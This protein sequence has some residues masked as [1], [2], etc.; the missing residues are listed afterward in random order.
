MSGLGPPI[1]HTLILASGSCRYLARHNCACPGA[2]VA[3]AILAPGGVRFD[4]R[5]GIV[6][7]GVCTHLV[8]TS[9]YIAELAAVAQ[10]LTSLGELVDDHEFRRHYNDALRAIEQVE[11]SWS[12]SYL[13]Y[14]ARCYY[15]SFTK[16]PS[17]DPFHASTGLR[18]PTRWRERDLDD[19][20]TEIQFP[21]SRFKFDNRKLEEAVARR[22]VARQR[23]TIISILSS[24]LSVA[25]D[26][27]YIAHLLKTV[28]DGTPPSAISIA[29]SFVPNTSYTTN[30]T[31]A[32]NEGGQ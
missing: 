22:V 13:G 24:Y 3:N 5:L 26:D 15:G 20:R 27:S 12:R 32:L 9:S 1:D 10:E 18:P 2:L 28:G 30:D 31:R 4:R 6:E 29:R 11:A 17:E 21:L 14:H 7:R 8:D 19:V 16:P 23:G 25:G